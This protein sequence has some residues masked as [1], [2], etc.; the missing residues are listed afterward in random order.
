MHYKALE[1]VTSHYR[2]YQDKKYKEEV[3]HELLEKKTI[4]RC[5]LDHHISYSST[6]VKG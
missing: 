4:S 3:F 2:I 6:E 1:F 5:Q